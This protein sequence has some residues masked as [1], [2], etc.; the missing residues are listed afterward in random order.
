MFGGLIIFF[1]ALVD[2]FRVNRSEL[3]HR[4][5]GVGGWACVGDIGSPRR[6]LSFLSCRLGWLPLPFPP[7]FT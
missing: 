1:C 6:G 2:L 4:V 7:L 3:Y 5:A